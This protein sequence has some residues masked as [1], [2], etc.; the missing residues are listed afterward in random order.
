[1]LAMYHIH[2]EK[3]MPQKS[4]EELEFEG[5][6]KLLELEESRKAIE[7]AR[8]NSLGIVRGVTAKITKKFGK[9]TATWQL[10]EQVFFLPEDQYPLYF[11]GL[12]RGKAI[13]M[14]QGLNRCNIQL[15][16]E[17]QIPDDVI[18]LS[19]KAKEDT[20]GTWFIEISKNWKRAGLLSPSR[21]GE[22]NMS[23]VGDMLEKAGIKPAPT[24]TQQS[25]TEF[26]AEQRRK[27]QER[28]ARF[29]EEYMKDIPKTEGDAQE[30]L[31]DKYLKGE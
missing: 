23:W 6:K 30:N 12:A 2:Q 31:I 28:E 29:F 11:R 19:A 21:Q 22:S 4:Q 8:L 1:M 3:R 16:E 10:F 17:Q 18:C 24:S 26:Q 13:N 7:A 9:N 27:M 14:T 25:E 20:D 5:R 15:A